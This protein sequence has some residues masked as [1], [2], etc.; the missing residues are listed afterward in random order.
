LVYLEGY[1]SKFIGSL[2]I[3]IFGVTE[4]TFSIVAVDKE[5]REVGFAIASCTWNSGLVCTARPGKGAIASQAKGNFQF[6]SEFFKLLEEKKDL[7]EILKCFT[8]IDETI[9]NRQIGM[10]TYEGDSFAFTGEECDFW[11]GHKTG[12]S[13]SCQG[14]TLSGPTVITKMA[15]TFEETKGSLTKKLYAALQA[16]DEAGG[17][18][19]GKQSARLFVTKIDED[20][21]DGHHVVD[22]IIADHHE[23][24]KEI[25]RILNIYK[26]QLLLRG[27]QKEYSKA[28]K[29]GKRIIL[30]KMS[31]FL[32]NKK[33]TRYI[34]A[35]T[36]LGSYYYELGEVEKAIDTFRIVIEISP[37]IRQSLTVSLR[38]KEK[39]PEEIIEEI[40][41]K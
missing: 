6:L 39:M 20:R 3:Q 22:F 23:P 31:Q 40:T 13:Y 35:W 41:K 28:N 29:E 14:N 33:E 1:S 17:D 36:T 10:V 15:D 25:G 32:R 38:K 37:N 11:A 12:I 8:N 26:N 18:V 9:Q 7:V 19:R 16:G 34:D 27:C 30:G 4:L 21:A 24:I 5:N 2:S